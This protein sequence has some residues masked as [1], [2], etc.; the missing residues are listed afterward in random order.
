MLYSTDQ[1]KTATEEE[2]KEKKDNEGGGAAAGN[3]GMQFFV[4][5][6]TFTNTAVLENDWNIMM[7][8]TCFCG[9]SILLTPWGEIF[10]F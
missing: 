1:E 2:E 6:M 8:Q 4:L 5:L 7:H 10:S 3:L 9:F